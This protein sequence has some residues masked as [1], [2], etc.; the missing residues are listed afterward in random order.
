M[1]GQD[2][3]DLRISIHGSSVQQV[4]S[5]GKSK[6]RTLSGAEASEVPYLTLNF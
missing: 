6:E 4:M 1:S 2:F 5:A 3:L